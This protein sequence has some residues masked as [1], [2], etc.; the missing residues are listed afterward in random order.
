[1]A[2]VLFCAVCEISHER[3]EEFRLALF[4]DGAL[5]IRGSAGRLPKIT[6]WQPVLLRIGAA[7]FPRQCELLLSIMRLLL[8]AAAFALTSF[9]SREAPVSDLATER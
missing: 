6:G 7:A 2:V 3:H 9:H 4:V 1:V 8:I 5:K